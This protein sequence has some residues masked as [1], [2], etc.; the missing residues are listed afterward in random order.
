MPL[1]TIKI[2]D[3]IFM[4]DG[5]VGVGAV[6]EVTPGKLTVYIEGYGDIMI[7]PDQIASAHDGKVLVKPETLP[8]HVQ[9][10]LE[11]VHDGEYR[12]PSEA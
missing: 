12:R 7:G 2:D 5:A 4:A 8:D 10:H 1:S 11:H 9:S 6:R 3:E